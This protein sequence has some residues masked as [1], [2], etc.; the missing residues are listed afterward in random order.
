MQSKDLPLPDVAKISALIDALR[1][2][3]KKSAKAQWED[4]PA[5]TYQAPSLASWDAFMWFELV[6]DWEMVEFLLADDLRARRLM[7]SLQSL[8]QW[9]GQAEID[10]ILAQVRI[11]S[12]KN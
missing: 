4:N 10:E 7:R 5:D 11:M 3:A 1:D 2:C 8:L 6:K 12:L 9:Y